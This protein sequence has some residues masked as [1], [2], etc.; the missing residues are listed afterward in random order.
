MNMVVF[1]EV[2]VIFGYFKVVKD[3]KCILYN[4]VKCI[5]NYGKK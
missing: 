4:F 3:I 5:R 2:F 1:V